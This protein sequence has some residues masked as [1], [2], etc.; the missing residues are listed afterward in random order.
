LKTIAMIRAFAVVMG[1]LAFQL[2]AG[3]A[4][5][6]ETGAGSR[7][8]PAQV[9]LPKQLSLD[10]A[11]RIFRT[12]GLDLMIADAS[13]MSAEGD[14]QTAAQVFNP[15]VS[16][17]G[18]P[19]FNYSARPP[20]SGCQQYSIGWGVSDNAAVMDFLSG[21][22]GLR[23]KAAKAALMAAKLARADAQRT[24]E[25]QVKSQYAQ[26]VLAKLNLDF[27]KEIQVSMV[28][29]LE[30][31]KLRY[32]Q[33]IDEGALARIE[34]QKLEGDQTVDNAVMTYRQAQVGLAFLLGVR[35]AVPDY[36]VDTNV[37]KYRVPSLLSSATQSSL[38]K[39][40]MDSR[41][42]LK[43]LAYQRERA[44]AS[45]D[46]AKRQIFPDVAFG[47]TYSQIGMGQN[48]ASPPTLLFGIS[49][50][51]P[52]FYQQQ[53][54]IRRAR[55]DLDTQALTHAKV[56]SQVV[57]DVGTAFSAF[58]ANK[59]LVERME[60]RLLSRAKTARDIVE[61]QYK[62]GSATLMDFLDALRTY[63]ATNQEY[64]GDLA[65][66]WTAVYQLEQAV[67]LEMRG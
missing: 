61:T 50:N 46:L 48:A 20:C 8:I 42:D 60:A 31:T 29:T 11:L 37:L 56:T 67:G 9:T 38:V 2:V 19:I 26:V 21:K 65:A 66:Y 39:M 15:N 34:V 4:Q 25:F 47:L 63:I 41:P 30:L 36:D 58:T 16:V 1:L 57:T 18:G 7:Y 13:I 54:E 43:Q 51:V 23:V 10:E 52:V 28:R 59:E 5:A 22:R 55:A 3:A 32:P 35:A 40:A 12:H 44:S 49:F 14:V 6:D 62:A 33:V 53:G 24:L 17:I 64:F 27:A 45:I